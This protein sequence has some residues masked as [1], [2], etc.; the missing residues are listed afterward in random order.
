MYETILFERRDCVA[1]ITLNRPD[2]MNSITTQLQSELLQA[3]DK[4]AADD[5]V[6]VGFLTGAGRAFCGGYD[7]PTVLT[8]RGEV[9]RKHK[10][11]LRMVAFDKPIMAAVNGYVRLRGS[12]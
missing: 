2:K 1:T 7:V 11:I 5:D 3:L 6:V 9:F 4:A 10:I 12:K 8:T